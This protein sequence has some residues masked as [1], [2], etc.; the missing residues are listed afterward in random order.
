MPTKTFKDLL[1]S[2]GTGTLGSMTEL[3]DELKANKVDLLLAKL[4]LIAFGYI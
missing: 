4:I 1:N 2:G 3:Q